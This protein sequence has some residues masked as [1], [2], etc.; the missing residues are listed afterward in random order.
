VTSVRA[1]LIRGASAVACALPEP[2]LVALAEAAGELWYRATPARAARA[3]RN[4][5]RVAEA[6]AREGRGSALAR[7]AASDPRALELLVRRAYRHAARYYLEVARTPALTPDEVMERLDLETPEAVADMVAG[8]RAVIVVGAHFGAI[9][10]PVVY[11]AA[12]QGYQYTAPMETVPDP[13]LQAWIERSRS[14]AGIR[15]VPIEHARR[16]LAATL[17]TGHSVGLVADRDL[18]GGGIPMPF[19]GYPASIP[20]GPAL[21][22]VETGAPLFVGG[23]RRTSKG[24]F[25]GR[26]TL[27]EVPADGPRRERVL[28]LMRRTVA[29]FEDL[30][31]QAPEQWWAVCQPIWP[32]LEGEAPSPPS[33]ADRAASGAAGDPDAPEPAVA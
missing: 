9:E 19:F 6:C 32:D 31:A 7:R 2:P 30:I 28:T 29:V 27:L 8:K 4:L 11:L 23:A 13:G 1:A 5:R 20:A 17:R 12:R 3:R 18:T 24:H 10:V 16:E 15:I 26:M 22:A 25:L 33:A 21:L 14:S